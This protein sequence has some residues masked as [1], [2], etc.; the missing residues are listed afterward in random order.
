MSAE[1]R[2][3]KKSLN[4]VIFS[5]INFSFYLSSLNLGHFQ[6]HSKPTMARASICMVKNKQYDTRISGDQ[7]L[8]ITP[9]LHLV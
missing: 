7:D 9:G 3:T 6:T 4:F 5:P 8:C 2:K 1:P